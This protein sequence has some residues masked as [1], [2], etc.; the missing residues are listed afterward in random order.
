[1]KNESLDAAERRWRN[2]TLY[3]K[4]R[5]RGWYR[6]AWLLLV[7]AVTLATLLVVSGEAPLVDT[8]L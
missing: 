3:R 4:G 5:S 7:V 2:K 1:M 8:L 6:L